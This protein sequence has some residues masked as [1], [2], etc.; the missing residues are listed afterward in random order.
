M[1]KHHRHTEERL[2]VMLGMPATHDYMFQ[3]SDRAPTME[4]GI[5][6]SL[7]TWI[8]HATDHGTD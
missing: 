1:S 3:Y 6:C 8:W 4:T 5:R 7:W 2:T